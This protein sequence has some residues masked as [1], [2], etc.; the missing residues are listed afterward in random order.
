MDCEVGL[1]AIDRISEIISAFGIEQKKAKQISDSVRQEFSG[2][3]IYIP[4]RS[5]FEKDQMRRELLSGVYY[6]NV[7]AKYKVSNRTALR[8]LNKIRR[9]RK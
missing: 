7:A 1:D 9:R 5:V 2:E 6:K 4:K 3:M 8:L